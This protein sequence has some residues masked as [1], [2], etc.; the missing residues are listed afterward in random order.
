MSKLYSVNFIINILNVNICRRVLNVDR[1]FYCQRFNSIFIVILSYTVL[2]QWYPWRNWL[3]AFETLTSFYWLTQVSHYSFSISWTRIYPDGTSQNTNPEVMAY[4]TNLVNELV[5]NGIQP[6]VTLYH[7]DLPQA[8]QNNGG[9][10]DDS[11][12][13]L[14][15]KYAR[16]MFTSLGDKVLLT[17][18]I[19]WCDCTL[20]RTR[21]VTS[22]SIGCLD[23]IL[24]WGLQYIRF[25]IVAHWFKAHA[26]SI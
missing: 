13:D 4:Y 5:A 12:V 22:I 11:T 26:V 8:I 25:K 6:V 2:T 15:E 17:H 23:T 14:F 18:R 1:S 19:H 3:K 9:W 7:Y 16:T 20:Y 24:C 21:N 10:A